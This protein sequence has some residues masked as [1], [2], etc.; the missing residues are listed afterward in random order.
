MRICVSSWATPDEDVDR[1][2]A[3]I[4]R[5]ARDYRSAHEVPA[6]ITGLS[7]SLGS[8][9]DGEGFRTPSHGRRTGKRYLVLT[10][11]PESTRCGTLSWVS[12]NIGG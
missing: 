12:R 3:A 6:E 11:V 9:P 2:V 10:H 7:Q 4:L 8:V 1:G 5:A